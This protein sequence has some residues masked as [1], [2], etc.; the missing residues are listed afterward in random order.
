VLSRGVDDVFHAYCRLA[1]GD[2]KVGVAGWP[3]LETC[4]VAED[5]SQS[6]LRSQKEKSKENKRITK[7]GTPEWD[8][9]M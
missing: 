6:V 3:W 5:R 4:S 1:R 8:F 2:C 9:L 7:A